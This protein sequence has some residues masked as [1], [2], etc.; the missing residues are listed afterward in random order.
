MNI[1]KRHSEQCTTQ[2]SGSLSTPLLGRGWGRLS[3]GRGGALGWVLLLLI[4]LCSLSSFAQ[5]TI[6]NPAWPLDSVV[7]SSVH[8]YTVSGDRNYTEPS[9]FV[10]TVSGGR[11]FNDVNLISMAGDGTTATVMGNSS[12][13]TQLFVV[14]DSFD[15]PLDTGY[16]YVYEISSDGCQ[17]S[18]LD[19]GKFQGMRVKVSSPPQARF[20]TDQTIV[21]SNYDSARVIME[22]EGMPPYDLIYSINGE[23]H[24]M[25]INQSDLAD[26]DGDNEADNI[27]FFHSNFSTITSDEVY[28]YE[29]VEVS[30]GGVPGDI[31]SFPSHTLIAHVQPPAPEIRHE[32]TEVTA[33]YEYVYQFDNS[34]VSPSQWYWTLRD[35]NSNLVNDR[36]LSND[37]NFQCMFNSSYIPGGYY[38]EAQYVDT[39]NCESPFDKLD[40]ELYGLPTIQFIG[41]DTIINCSAT[42]LVP[43]EVFQLKVKYNG[44]RTYGYKYLVYDYNGDPAGSGEMNELNDWESTIIID[45]DFINDALPEEIRPWKVVITEAHTL[46]GRISVDIVDGQNERVILIY[47]KPFIHD[48]ID[49]AN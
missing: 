14:W 2:Q 30:S 20:I 42:T 9:S 17:R 39:Y 47:P 43:D 31:L 16:V 41:D 19:E 36:A 26:W 3:F 45:N 5:V 11:L 40:I 37:P 10:W 22:I 8:F 4:S 29:I 49:F 1:F 15:T 25:H 12:N 18:D 21:C 33:G 44:A 24:S 38:V 35:E 32:W 27:S 46:D 6:P 23:Q 7:N 28:V 34:G 48:D 13:I